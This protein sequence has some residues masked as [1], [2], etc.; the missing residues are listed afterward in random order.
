MKTLRVLQSQALAIPE[1]LLTIKLPGRDRTIE[2][3]INHTVEIASN[4]LEVCAGEQ[5]DSIR[6]NAEPEKNL[7]P[8][9]LIERIDH[10]N[11]QIK[12]LKVD[13]A[14]MVP[15]FYGEQSMSSVLER[16]TWHCMQHIR[17][18]E[19]FMNQHGITFASNITADMMTDLPMPKEVWD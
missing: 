9:K 7:Q 6:A 18:L 11:E 8:R 4:F 15:T 12:Q 14:H 16:C 2:S 3:L 1:E 19:Y 13:Y 17:Q 5:F 10:I